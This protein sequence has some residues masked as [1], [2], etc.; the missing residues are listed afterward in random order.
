MFIDEGVPIEGVKVTL[1]S[2]VQEKY[3]DVNG[4]AH[5]ENVEPG[6]HKVLLAYEDFKGE[7]DLKVEGE[8]KIQS[9]KMEVKMDS[10][11]S[12]LEVRLVILGLVLVVGVLG[13]ALY[14]S[15]R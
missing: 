7:Q 5:F 4:V 1:H 11:F 6:D 2:R 10:G 8:N 3:T 12:S 14:K 15:K 13:F 9:V